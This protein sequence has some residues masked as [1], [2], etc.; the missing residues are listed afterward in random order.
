MKRVRWENLKNVFRNIA[1]LLD[2]SKNRKEVELVL[3]V[4][5]TESRQMSS[6]VDCAQLGAVIF[7]NLLKIHIFK[8]YKINIIPK[9][10]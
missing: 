7:A 4:S 9:V 6:L 10:F 2:P 1:N 3:I 5:M 8:N